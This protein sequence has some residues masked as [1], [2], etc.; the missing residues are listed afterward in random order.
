VLD[1]AQI[2]ATDSVLVL[3]RTYPGDPELTSYLRHAIDGGVLPLHAFVTS[4]LRASQSQDLQNNAT[5]D[6]LCRT[7][8]DLH[9]STGLPPLGSIVSFSDSPLATLQDGLALL[10]IAYSLP[11]SPFH[12]P[13][14]SASQLVLLLLNCV[15]DVSQISASQ[16]MIHF[17][18]GTDLLQNF[19]LLPDIRQALENF[20]VTLSFLIGDDEKAREAQMMH[21][22]QLQV[23]GYG[24]GE[25]I[26]GTSSQNDTVTLCLELNHLVRYL[27]PKLMIFHL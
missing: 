14:T 10:R 13:A 7:A 19:R 20:V 12:Q 3:Y 9:Y 18:A 5:L 22:L 6:R 4:F 11:G 21:S 8:L 27:P 1:R 23:G 24:K 25:L 15:T 17:A 2:F 26:A 16:A